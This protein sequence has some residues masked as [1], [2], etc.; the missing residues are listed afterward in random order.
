MEERER[1][2]RG[3]DKFSMLNKFGVLLKIVGGTSLT[4]VHHSVAQCIDDVV[5][6]SPKSVSPT[7][8]IAP[9]GFLFSTKA[10]E[11]KPVLLW[12][13]PYEF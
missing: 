7:S 13:C 8:L 5:I 10:S 9:Y 3:W 4:H 12:Q 6:D 11:T 2:S 1:V